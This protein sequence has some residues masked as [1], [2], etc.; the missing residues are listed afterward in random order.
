MHTQSP[1]GFTTPVICGENAGQHVYVDIGPDSGAS[2]KLDFTFGT[3]TTVSRLFEIKV[4]QVE[5]WAE[6]RPYDSGCLQYHTG[7][8]GRITSFNFAQTSSSNYQH[9]PSQK[10]VYFN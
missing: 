10:Q 9:L 7:T 4:T 6:S 8:T 3:S 2:A 1:S 5:C